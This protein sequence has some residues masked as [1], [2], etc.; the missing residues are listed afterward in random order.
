M[1][2]YADC[3][4]CKGSGYT[5][6]GDEY[7]DCSNCRLRTREAD[8]IRAAAEASVEAAYRDAGYADMSP[9]E[10]RTADGDR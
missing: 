3:P 4:H 1:T 7:Q 6:G 10:Q 8:R 2:I 9:L 5:M